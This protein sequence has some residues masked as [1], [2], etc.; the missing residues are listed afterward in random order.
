MQG[1]RTITAYKAP[2]SGMITVNVSLADKLNTFY[3]KAAATHANCNANNNAIVDGNTN[4]CRQEENINTGNA[5][6]ISKHEIKR[7]FRRVNTRKPAGPKGIPGQFLRIC[8]NQ[9][10]P[11]FKEIFNLFL[12]QSVISTCFKDSITCFCLKE[13]LD[14]YPQ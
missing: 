1:L 10:A 2:P 13:I 5:L 3:F 4:G 12:S 14:C 6:I 9:L 7:A 11:V 8:T